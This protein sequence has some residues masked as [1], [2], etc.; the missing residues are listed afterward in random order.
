LVAAEHGDDASVLVALV[1]LELDAFRAVKVA[2][3]VHLVKFVRLVDQVLV[4]DVDRRGGTALGKP[5]VEFLV[6]E[7]RCTADRD[8]QQ[9]ASACLPRGEIREADQPFA[10]GG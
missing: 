8:Q 7:G 4:H 9:L 1:F 3:A 2:G 10:L 5:L 6:A